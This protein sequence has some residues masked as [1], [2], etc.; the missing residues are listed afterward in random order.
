[1]S[2]RHKLYKAAKLQNKCS[3]QIDYCTDLTVLA[4]LFFRKSFEYSIFKWKWRYMFLLGR[5]YVRISS[6]V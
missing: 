5:L 2:S 6:N 3:T 1:M 4:V